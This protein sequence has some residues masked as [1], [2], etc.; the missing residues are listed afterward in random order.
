MITTSLDRTI[1]M[2]VDV[3]SAYLSWSAAQ[4]LEN[5]CKIDYRK[6]AAIVGGNPKTR[7]GIV[8]AKSIPA[9]RYG[10]KTAETLYSALK[11]C[12]QLKII[13]PD[14]QLYMQCS[15]ALKQLLARYSP[16]LQRFSIDEYFVDFSGIKDCQKDPVGF[17]HK[18][19]DDIYQQLG[20]TVNIGISSNK[21]LAKIAGD[22]EKPNKVH[23]LFKS[24]IA[25]KLWPLP[26]DKLYMVGRH[27]LPKLQALG[28]NT[29]GDLAMVD[30]NFINTKLKKFGL[31]LRNL[32]NGKVDNL[33]NDDPDRP[34]K[35]IGNSTTIAFDITN[36]NE[37]M[38]VLLSLTEMVSM[39][40]RAK[41]R[42][43]GTVSISIKSADFSKVLHQKQLNQPTDDTSVIYHAVRQLFCEAWQGQPVRLLGVRLSNL[44]DCSHYQLSLL[45][46]QTSEKRRQ[47]NQTIDA[48]RRRFGQKSI[49][50]AT[51]SH[52]NFAPI[53][54]NTA[55]IDNF[56]ALKSQL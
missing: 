37:A 21:L 1:I 38:M 10:I 26:V 8:L 23:T 46:Y 35:G 34:V 13:A 5:G 49:F 9:K 20:F 47:L 24:E 15:A 41:A 56:P 44:T 2:H 42:L 19:K 7:Q 53:K 29:V 52:S 51:F 14:Y 3:N 25:T 55:D 50:R 39:R 27:T 11:K 33:I 18:L 43:A 30:K 22:F 36:R 12:P 48:L 45:D 31:V 32:A 28:I 4:A 6:I 16:Q 17:A 54:G 40:L